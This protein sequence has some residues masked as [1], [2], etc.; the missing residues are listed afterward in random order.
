MTVGNDVVDLAEPANTTSYARDGFV[1][2]V[3]APSE[4]AALTAATDPFVRLWSL[5]AAKEAAYKVLDKLGRTPGFAH[6][7]LVVADDLRSVTWQDVRLH[8]W[9]EVDGAARVVHAVAST[10]AQRPRAALQTL[11]ADADPSR[12]VRQLARTVLSAALGCSRDELRVERP[13]RPDGWDGFGPPRLLRGD[14][15]VP[16]TDISLS[17]DGRFV[18]VAARSA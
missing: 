7:R 2:R 1:E 6:R 14:L 11:E 15:P 3:C 12:S 5:F 16:G 18:A 10:H 13:E 9:V 17:H 4:R 8:L